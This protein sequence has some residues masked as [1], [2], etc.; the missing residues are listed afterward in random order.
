[1]NLF[2]EVNYEFC[3]DTINTSR[4]NYVAVGYMI[5]FEHRQLLS[6]QVSRCYEAQN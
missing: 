1:M 4:Y 2:L 3:F 5:F 6:R